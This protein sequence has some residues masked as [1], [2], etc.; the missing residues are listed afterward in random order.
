M[1]NPLAQELN[2]QI[3]KGNP[4]LLETLS[5][6][7]RALY[8]PKGILTQTAEAKEKAH[9]YNATIGIAKRAGTPLYL[10]CINEFFTGC[11]PEEL[12]PYAPSFGIPAL[13][14]TWQEK[15]LAENPSLEGK[16]ASLPI[17]TS[18]ITHGLSL[19]A[20]LFVNPGDTVLVPDKV[21]GNYLMI[22]KVRHGAAVAK[23]PLLSPTGG[24]DLAGFRKAVLEAAI[25]GKI[26]V[27]LNFPNN[28]TGYAPTTEEAL[29]IRDV[30][31][32]A[33][34]APCDIV[35]VCDDSYF[36]L[37]YEDAVY[38]ESLFGLLA[39]LHPR[40]TSVKLDG[41]TK[42]DFV[43]GFR[44]GFITFSAISKE[45]DVLSCLEK[46][47]AGA[48]RGGI[49][50]CAHPSQSIL[51]KAMDSPDFEQQRDAA[52]AILRDRAR[53]VKRLMADEKY[54]PAWEPYP[55]NSGYF[56]CVK[57]KSLEAEAFRVRLLENYGVGVIATSDTDIRVA[58][59]CVEV[60]Q[61]Q[62]LFDLMLRCAIEM[63]G[64]GKRT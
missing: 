22:Y 31:L 4:R 8:Y 48:V 37:F 61:L 52:R 50:N 11:A 42:E 17:V 1:V 35:A 10:D 44:T 32:E 46:K 18:G 47:C 62:E 56:M 30:L 27:I 45:G 55:F 21:W 43:W 19:V 28:P 6:L 53:E 39:G 2:A 38:P 24:L 54:R 29:A 3:E 60:E 26:V 15:Q 41:A 51:H 14:R 5:E 16:P 64:E 20:D 59:S 34:Q 63:R 13:R 58:F 40:L 12:F 23:Y 9:R 25:K 57:L 36:G 7:G 33:A 49:S